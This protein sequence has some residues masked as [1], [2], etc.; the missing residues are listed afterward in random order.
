[1]PCIRCGECARVC[2]AT[3]LPQQLNWQIVNQQWEDAAEYGLSDCIECGCCDFVCPSHIPLVEWFRFG[4]A[5]LLSL[6]AEREFA[7]A[8]KQKF[9]VREARLARDKL[10]RRQRIEEKKNALRDDAEKRKK[11]AEAIS[12]AHSTQGRNT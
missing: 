5:E 10:E 1:M 11:L 3:L 6:A 4:K 2:P 8:A 7:A 12:R 9:E